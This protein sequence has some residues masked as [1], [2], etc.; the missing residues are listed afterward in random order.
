MDRMP[1][2]APLQSGERIRRK[3]L[4]P[5][6]AT[7]CV[8]IA[9]FLLAAQWYLHQ[10]MRR[11]LQRRQKT[12][13]NLFG[14]MVEQRT[15]LMKSFLQQVL[16]DR[17]LQAAMETADRG[18]LLTL[19][20]SMVGPLRPDGAISHFYYIRPDAQVFLRVYQPERFGD[21]V[22][23]RTFALAREG[24]TV[25]SGVELGPLGTFTL[26]VVAPWKVDGRLLGYV[27]VGEDIGYLIRRLSDIGQF[28]FLMTLRKDYLDS[29]SWARG[30]SLF[31]RE[32]D[33]NRY[34]DRVVV[35]Q[36]LP[37]ISP[38]LDAILADGRVAE[39]EI[40]LRDDGRVFYG[41]FLPLTDVGC[42]RVGE[43]LVMH[44]VTVTLRE[45]RMA[46]AAAILFC[47]LLGG[48]LML[49]T[50]VGVERLDRK[51]ALTRRR[52]EREVTRTLEAN[53]RLEQ[54]VHERRLAE[55]ALAEAR[56][57]L[58]V[59]VAERT[60]ELAGILRSVEDI[61]FAVDEGG[62]IVLL[63]GSAEAFLGCTHRESQ[64]RRIEEVIA[65][66]V[67]L[68][69]VREA[70]RQ[71]RSTGSFD[72]RLPGPEEKK[73]RIMQ[74]RISVIGEREGDFGGI[75]FLVHDVTEE[76]E[77]DRLKNEFI[78]T[79]AH[80]LRTPMTT[81]LG[82]SELLLTHE[83]F[84]PEEEREFLTLIREKAEGISALL[85]DL[86][87]LSR[88][89]SG[90]PIE[91]HRVPVRAEEI[92]RPVVAHY[93]KIA[94]NHS[95]QLEL[96]DGEAT[97]SAD[98]GK[99]GQVMENLLSNAVKYSPGGGLVRIAGRGDGGA[100]QITVRD[101]GIGMTPD[102][103]RQ[104]FQKFYRADSSDTAVHGTGLGLTIVQHIVE[105]HGG[106]VWMESR[107]G[108][109]TAVHFVLPLA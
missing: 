48:G 84:S 91:I 103:T 65:H 109:G 28:R 35:Q 83:G 17:Q 72:F 11:E 64:G 88:L 8:F 10:E 73:D 49:T 36:N 70:L 9:V 99:I 45:F 74:A 87:D 29:A 106:R 41:N 26:R 57:G 5:M 47:F 52:L 89:E 4:I 44:D 3:I 51:L 61:L 34:P 102:Q 12:V 101:E 62:R 100:Y 13:H 2:N 33:W 50:S 105:A 77:M 38:E 54:E 7:L 75:A 18:R 94:R 86:L 60:A 19:S 78:S 39:E 108:E 81:I 107:F 68:D 93:R 85:D 20:E 71:R 37:G 82:Y 25:A 58:E 56:D 6:A 76:R 67:L 43:L 32:G 53:D 15:H 66:P 16:R 40:F 46:M 104:A 42:R 80:E 69:Q 79:A 31:G 1:D 90:R 97:V 23:R 14:E 98:P 27:E 63:N 30:M 59:R 55:S 95:F 96:A 92:I 21:V 24:G 22:T